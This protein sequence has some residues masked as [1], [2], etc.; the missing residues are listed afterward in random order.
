MVTFVPE[1]RLWDD[2]GQRLY[3]TQEERAAFLNA[4]DK[5]G[6][7]KRMMCHIFHFTGCRTSEVMEIAPYRVNMVEKEIIIRTIKKRK[8]DN[9]G[10]RKKP[11][12]RAVPVPGELVKDLDLVFDLK[13]SQA[14][15]KMNKTPLW[16]CSRSTIWRTIKKV[17]AAAEIEG[18]Q[19]TCKGLR[20]AFAIAQLQGG[21]PITLVRDLLGHADIRTTEIYLKVIGREKRQLVMNAWRRPAEHPGGP[22]QFNQGAAEW[23]G[24]GGY[25][26]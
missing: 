4:A 18:P 26:Y 6:R 24:S 7:E 1:M 11:Q 22:G 5:E 13:R 16:D 2:E 19:A 17:M 21:A 8:Y 20:H 23:P 9:E 15:K 25:N 3:L 12:F 14:D 10:R